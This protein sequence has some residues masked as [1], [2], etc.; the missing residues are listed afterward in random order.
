MCFAVRIS[1]ILNLVFLYSG[2]EEACVKNIEA[3]NAMSQ[4][5]RTSLGPNG[6]SKMLINQ[7]DKLSVTSDAATIIKE[8]DVIHPAAKM[9]VLASQMQEH[10][11]MLLPLTLTWIIGPWRWNEF[12]SRLWRGAAHSSWQP[13]PHGLAS[14]GDC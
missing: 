4:I 9:L 12:C 8:L 1:P 10:V 6:M 5:T 11:C 13:H 7:H 14:F 2:V 3:C